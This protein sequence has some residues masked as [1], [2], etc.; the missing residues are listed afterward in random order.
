MT[1]PGS[2]LHSARPAGAGG[3]SALLASAL[4]ALALALFAFY[5]INVAGQ[6]VPVRLAVPAWQLRFAQG[7]IAPAPIALIGLGLLQLASYIDRG[8]GALAARRRNLSSLAIVAAVGFLLLIP[9]QLHAANGSIRAMNA[10][11]EA[12][13]QQVRQNLTL[14]RQ[15]INAAGSMEDLQTRIKEIQAPDLILDVANLGKPLPQI[16]QALL[17]S[18]D[19]SERQ[20]NRAIGGGS[21][22][23]LWTVLQRSLQGVLSCLA[24]AFG[25]A[26][27]A[28]RSGSD[29]S[30]LQELR[31]G[32]RR[33]KLARL[34]PR[35]SQTEAD[36]LRELSREDPEP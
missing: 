32:W 13:I 28:R 9:L 11:R 8:N 10:G 16:K 20:I 15:Q 27:L 2:Q 29:L 7:A 25:F 1:S 36:Y 22:R 14:M 31:S 21:A 17:A 6:V 19:S 23:R 35:S 24:L 3:E 5:L 18:V 12:R 30:L 4:S 34:A 33:S 26:A